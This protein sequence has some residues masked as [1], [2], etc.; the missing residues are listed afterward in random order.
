MSPMAMR[1]LIFSAVCVVAAAVIAGSRTSAQSTDDLSALNQQVVELYQAGKYAEAISIAERALTVAEDRFGTDSIQVGITLNNLAAL[2]D[3]EGRSAEALPLLKR[4]QAIRE[5][6]L[7]KDEDARA[8]SAAG[9]ERSAEVE[10]LLSEGIAAY[11]EGEFD[12]AI[13]A[14]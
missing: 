10:R 4:A 9:E 6:A 11:E 13:A 3:K 14:Y 1:C 12:R 2:C 7:K 8:A 5:G